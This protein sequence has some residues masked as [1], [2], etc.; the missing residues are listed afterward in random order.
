MLKTLLATEYKNN[1]YFC[2]IKE[3]EGI[4]VLIKCQKIN[5]QV[6]SRYSS[7]SVQTDKVTELS[8]LQ[9]RF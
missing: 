8:L 4:K 6:L 9:D 2:F 1:T 5:G 3:I 7:T